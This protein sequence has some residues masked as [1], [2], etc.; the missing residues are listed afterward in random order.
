M[1]DICPTITVE[2][3]D[4]YRKQMERIEIF[5][6]RIHVDVADGNFA[7]RKLIN[8]DQIWWHGN[9]TI[10]LHVMYQQPSEYA[11]II[12]ALKPQLV[13]VHAEADGDFIGF[14]DALH[15]HGIEVGVA[16]LPETPAE[17]LEPAIHV[18]DHVLIFS[19]KLGHYGGHTD[20]KLLDKV[21][22]LKSMKPQLE[23][24]WDGGIDDQNIAALVQGGVDVLN[25]GGFIQGSNEP[26]RAYATLK[27]ITDTGA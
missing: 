18:V 16:L 14:A 3:A 21:G 12:L 26:Q 10:D 19:G 13:I 22:I 1:V 5:A 4:D 25:V 9:R 6:P 20:L 2:N 15:S 7:P 17:I 23:I 11:D 24:G 27:Y 8:L